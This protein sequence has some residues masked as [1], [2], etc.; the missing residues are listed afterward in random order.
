[1]VWFGMVILLSRGARDIRSTARTA[2]NLAAVFGRNALPGGKR[3]SLYSIQRLARR[4]PD[5]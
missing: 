4:R 3:T 5:W 1:M 2:R